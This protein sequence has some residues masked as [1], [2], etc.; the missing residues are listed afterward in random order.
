MKTCLDSRPIYLTT[1]EHI[2]GHFTVVC[3]ALQT[4]RFM[5]YR[6]YREEGHATEKLG[7]ACS[8]MVTAEAVLEELRNMRE[9]GFTRRKDT[10]SSTGRERTT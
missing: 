2:R 8:S 10:T 1:E 7:R 9:E 5:M 3:L 4:L 6:L